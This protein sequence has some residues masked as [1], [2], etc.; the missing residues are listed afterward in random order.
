MRGARILGTGRALPSR[1]VTNA[2]L[3]TM[4]DTSEEWIVQRTGIRER[5]FVDPGTGASDLGVQA[6]RAAIERA[7]LV[8]QDIQFIVFATLSP[9][10]FFPGSGVF[11]QEKLGLDTIGALDVRTQCTGF[12]YG[13]SVAEAYV[14]AGFYDHVL[15][16][17][18]EVQSTGL[19]MSTAGR[20]VS[21]LFG[22]GGGAVIVGPTEPGKGIL[23]THLHSE[24]KYARELMVEAPASI[25]NPRISKEMIDA[26]RHLG[27]M[28]GRSVFIHAVRRF[29]EV[30]Q[31][32]LA[33]NGMTVS[34]LSIVIPHQAN[35]RIT[36]AVTKALGVPAEKVFSNIEKYGNTTA[37]SVPIALDEC[38]EQGRIREGDV[39]CLAAFG[40]GFTWASSLIRW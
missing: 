5:R 18:A 4:M 7:G 39:V 34:D 26:R 17:G 23:S 1:V 24:G 31:E 25:E 13:L 32:A 37:A 15:V 40:S 2:E 19:D 16:I 30:I 8:P 22:D 36:Q 28:N 29:P 35:L 27:T 9:D 6:A 20:D 33:E 11:V 21:V 14:K 12:I 38:V 10:L 3:T